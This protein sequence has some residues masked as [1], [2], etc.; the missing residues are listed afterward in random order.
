MRGQSGLGQGGQDLSEWGPWGCLRASVAWFQVHPGLEA[1][2]E[3][4]VWEGRV[5]REEASSCS[6]GPSSVQQ[7][8]LR[9]WSWA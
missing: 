7:G 8:A 5:W 9:A 1:L 6:G 2:G 4:E 3:E